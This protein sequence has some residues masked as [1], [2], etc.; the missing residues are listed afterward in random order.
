M[1]VFVPLL[2]VFG[3]QA[4]NFIDSTATRFATLI[5]PNT[6]D[7]GSLRYRY[8][9]NEYALPQ[10]AAHPIIGMG[11]GSVY[12]TRDSRIDFGIANYDKLAYIHDGHLWMLLKTGLL[13]YFLFV[14]VFLLFLQHSLANW[15]RIPDPYLKAIV[16][17]FAVTVVGLL[18]AT[19]VNPIF[20]ESYWSPLLGIMIGINEVIYMLNQDPKE[21]ARKLNV[22]VIFSLVDNFLKL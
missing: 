11:L 13:G 14:L 10:I 2:A 20:A 1:I 18:P 4:Q 16:L 7:E 5:N 8:V 21:A 19:S 9:E 22:N 15:K 3:N 17:T 6:L 12:R